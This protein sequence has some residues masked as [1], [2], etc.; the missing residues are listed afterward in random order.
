MAK[1]TR[2]RKASEN[3]APV[4]NG[5]ELGDRPKPGT[6]PGRN[7]GELRRHPPGSNGGVH[8]G[9]DLKPRNI[10]KAIVLKAFSDPGHVAPELGE[11]VKRN[12]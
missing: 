8:R 11:R 2:R 4:T 1:G 12:E 9:P 5:R 6:M 3:A 7:G 10:M